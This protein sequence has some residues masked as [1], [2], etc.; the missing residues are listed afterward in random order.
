MGK[1]ATEREEGSKG[2]VGNEKGGEGSQR[3]ERER[4][5]K[6]ETRHTNPSLLPA[7]LQVI[8]YIHLYSHKV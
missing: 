2:K 7:P 8:I 4:E 3:N 5:G 1:V 6:G